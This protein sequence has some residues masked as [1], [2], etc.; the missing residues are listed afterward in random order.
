[1]MGIL[2]CRGIQVIVKHHDDPH[3]VRRGAAHANRWAVCNLIKK[4]E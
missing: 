4:G 2:F 1:M 3:D